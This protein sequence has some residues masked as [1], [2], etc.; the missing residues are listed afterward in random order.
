MWGIQFCRSTASSPTHQSTSARI[1]LFIV[2]VA[3]SVTGCLHAVTSKERVVQA[4]P[5]AEAPVEVDVSL[6]ADQVISD[7]L[8]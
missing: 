2:A 7:A 6:A 1:L 4:P 3:V 8:R 5:L